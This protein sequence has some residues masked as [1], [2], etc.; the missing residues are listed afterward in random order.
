M[1]GQTGT[2]AMQAIIFEECGSPN[3]VLGLQDIPQPEPAHDQVRVRMLSSPI[4]PSDLMYIRGNYSVQ[5]TFPAT[6]GFEGV[7]VVEAHA[8]PPSH[9]L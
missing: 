5:P 2:A 3:E 6:P 8:L 9:Y 4:N 7:G 1:A